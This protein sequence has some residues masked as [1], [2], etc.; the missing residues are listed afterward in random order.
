MSFLVAGLG[1]EL[2]NWRIVAPIVP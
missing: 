1:H 2:V